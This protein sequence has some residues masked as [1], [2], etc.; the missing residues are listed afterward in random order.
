[1]VLVPQEHSVAAILNT[2]DFLTTIKRVSI[3]S[4][5]HG[6]VKLALDPSSQKIT[7]SAKTMDV[8]SATETLDA[9]V[10][11]EYQE[12]GFNH[13]YIID[14]LSVMDNDE[15]LFES[16]GA[17]KPGV[18]KTEGEDKFLYLTM[19]VRIDM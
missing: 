5:N 11:G 6:P 16:Q 3:T 18:L 4:G 12:T 8:A 19:P 7:V 1:E 14:G 17:L 13:Q 9:Q 10:E 15:V 2:A